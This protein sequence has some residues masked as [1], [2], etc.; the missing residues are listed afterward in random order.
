MDQDALKGLRR[1]IDDDRT[2]S[3]DL[4]AKRQSVMDEIEVIRDPD[5]RR[6][7]LYIVH[8][9]DEELQARAD[10]ERLRKTYKKPVR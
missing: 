7:S 4:R 10:L 9:L 6:S 1:W 3:R 8:L 2:P 5:I